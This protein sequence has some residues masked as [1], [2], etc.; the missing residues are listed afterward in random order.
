MF[1]S[2]VFGE[3]VSE[4]RRAGDR[5]PDKSVLANL[6][7]LIGNS[8]YGKCI[9]NLEK[10]KKVQY[11]NASEVSGVVNDSYFRDLD[12]LDEDFFEVSFNKK[13]VEFK[14]P[15]QI[16]FF[17]YG[18]AKLRMPNYEFILKLGIALSSKTNSPESLQ[19]I[20]ELSFI[21][22]MSSFALAFCWVDTFFKISFSVSS[23]LSSMRTF[24]G[25]FSDLSLFVM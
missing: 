16:G 11:F 4:A 20:V 22:L 6:M 21:K 8:G 25:V 3:S 17:V 23:F 10:H 7:K 5:D 19:P 2:S 9:T 15:I 18:Y 13:S 1:Q 14:L 24:T 12:E